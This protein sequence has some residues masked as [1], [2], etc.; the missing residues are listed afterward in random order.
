[1]Q[2]FSVNDVKIKCANAFIQESDTQVLG[3]P[4][5]WSASSSSILILSAFRLQTY[6]VTTDYGLRLLR[7]VAYQDKSPT[8]NNLTIYHLWHLFCYLFLAY[9]WQEF[10]ESRKR[11]LAEEEAKAASRRVGTPSDM[12]SDLAA[13]TTSSGTLKFKLN[14]RTIHSIFTM[15]PIVFK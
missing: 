15:Y 5:S 6:A 8:R 9:P 13:E 1:M 2:A 12:P 10:W 4:V 7:P 14:A 3:F 11:T